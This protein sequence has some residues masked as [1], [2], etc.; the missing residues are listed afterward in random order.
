[1]IDIKYYG[2]IGILMLGLIGRV[3]TATAGDCIPHE[4]CS[5]DYIW[6]E[7][8]NLGGGGGGGVSLAA[9]GFDVNV[10]FNENMVSLGYRTMSQ[11]FISSRYDR[12]GQFEIDGKLRVTSMSRVWHRPSRLGYVSSSIGLSLISGEVGKNCDQVP[13][14]LY[15]RYH[16]D[17]EKVSTVGVPMRVSAGFGRYVGI[18]AHLEL[19]LNP[20]VP[21]IIATFSFPIGKFT[22]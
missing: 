6:V 4:P 10:P 8:L 21:Y 9:A 19:N 16:C 18:A 1:M 3:D 7:A 14:F 17:R 15:P 13:S 12:G 11:G 20:E 5:P 2:A 22:R